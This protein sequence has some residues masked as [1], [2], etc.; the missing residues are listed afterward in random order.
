M[1]KLL[2]LLV[3][4]VLLASA[5]FAQE[6][7]SISFGA[8]GRAT[9]APVKIVADG[10]DVKTGA[11]V[12]GVA[13]AA[14]TE[15][16]VSAGL[17]NVGFNFMLYTG[18]TGLDGPLGLG[19]GDNNYLWA[20]PFK[21]LHLTVG[22]FLEDSLRGK[23]G[24]ANFYPHIAGSG[25]EDGIFTQ[26]N[27]AGGNGISDFAS[28]LLKITPIE[29]LLIAAQINAF[30]GAATDDNG[31]EVGVGDDGDLGKIFGSGQYAVG[32]TIP[33]IGLVR[34]QYVG[35]YSEY[36][37]I[38]A[39]F[40]YT[41][42]EDI[43]IDAGLKV[44]LPQELMSGTTTFNGINFSVGANLAFGDF[45]IFARI[46]TGFAGSE[47][48]GGTTTTSPFS[49]D[50]Y[51]SPSYNLSFAKIGLDLGL[52]VKTETKI[53]DAGQGDD[54]VALGAGVWIEKALGGGS[55]KA[56]LAFKFPL[57][58]NPFVFTIP[59]IIGISF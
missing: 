19:L 38:E 12:G 30:P 57:D 51:A 58:D 14:Y 55:L 33:N 39:A 44:W 15:F 26:F 29:N 40:A 11:G 13:N 22:K 7:P 18:Y 54:S 1:K 59:V 2:A 5:A 50:F 32:Y 31:K 28:A 20:Q 8:W 37:R 43:T 25:D 4:F 49:L 3:T 21:F 48:T 6:G 56:G 34:A 47:E 9:F 46:D 16:Y 52:N 35:S 45:G 24:Y 17:E 10:D 27:S 53:G 42:T 36:S 41:G 23:V